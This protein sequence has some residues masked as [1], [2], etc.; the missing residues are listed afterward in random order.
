MDQI[1]ELAERLGKAIANSQ[2]ALNMR[3]VQKALN[4]ESEISQVLKDFQEHSQK[5]AQLEGQQK[6]VEVDDKHKLQELHDK[7]AAS[8]TFKKFAAA[9][10]EYVDLMRRVNDA[11]RKYEAETSGNEQE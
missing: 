5:I 10:V 9:Q 11:L 2:Q 4:A 6:P 7:L 3:Q 8:E 1:I